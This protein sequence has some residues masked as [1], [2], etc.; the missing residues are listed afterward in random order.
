MARLID[1]LA[2]RWRALR[3]ADALELDAQYFDTCAEYCRL[4]A[5]EQRALAQQ[6]REARQN[7][8]YPPP[9]GITL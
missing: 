3:S 5:A 2:W 7:L 1:W 9:K 6:T 4:R 8:R